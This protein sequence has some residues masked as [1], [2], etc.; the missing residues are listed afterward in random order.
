[1]QDHNREPIGHTCPDIDKYIKEIKWQIVKDR[2]LQNMDERELYDTASSMSSQLEYCIGYLE[3][4]RSSNGKLRQWAIE[5]AER[6]DT[7]ETEYQL[8]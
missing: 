3:E 7:L 8:N 2:E 1:M 6:V 5:E 4:L